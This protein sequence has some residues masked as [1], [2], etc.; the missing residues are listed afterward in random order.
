MKL[1]LLGPPGAGKGT[2]AP[3]IS[4]LTGCAHIST[5]DM[6]RRNIKNQT[7]LGKRAADFMNEGRLVPD[8]LTIDMVRETIVNEHGSEN[9]ILDGFPR[10][11]EQA[12][13]L[14]AMLAGSGKE[15]DAVICLD[16]DEDVII[17]RLSG[18][19]V[20]E[21]CGANYNSNSLP[22]KVEGICDECGNK[23]IVREDD[24][25]ETV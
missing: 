5:G 20:C 10:T 4:R 2:L 16:V 24:Q 11:V 18:R 1:V 8:S 21:H 14:D 9:F 6:F 22:P 19:L 17:K 3:T 15:L 12:E 7:E 13:S 23:L 25:P